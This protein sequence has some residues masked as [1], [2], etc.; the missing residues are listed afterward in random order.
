MEISE[1]AKGHAR[2]YGIPPE[3]LSDPR[4]NREDTLEL[5]GE[6]GATYT[7]YSKDVTGWFPQAA[8]V[9]ALVEGD[10]AQRS[11]RSAHL[12]PAGLLEDRDKP[13]DALRK[14]A[15]RYGLEF[16]LGNTTAPF[17]AQERV[18]RAGSREAF[19]LDGSALRGHAVVEDVTY[20]TGGDFL[21]VLLALVVD[22]TAVRE[23]LG[24]KET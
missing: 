10:E 2:K 8:H 3:L 19:S 18:R 22:A 7:L 16:R 14:L 6:D 12:V 1:R 15:G 17:F 4:R 21:H 13:L 24:L 20:R 23:A 5:P 9:V 11:V